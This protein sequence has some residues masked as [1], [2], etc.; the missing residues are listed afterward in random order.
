MTLKKNDFEVKTISTRVVEK[1]VVCQV[2]PTM[3]TYP[4]LWY[5]N[6]YNV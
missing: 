2:N 5:V 4:D 6:S 3:P 1:C